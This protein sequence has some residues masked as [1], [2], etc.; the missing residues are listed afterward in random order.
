MPHAW[1]SVP[2]STDCPVHALATSI[3]LYLGF[4]PSMG[5]DQSN[6]TRI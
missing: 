4:R 6:D 1:E 2:L 3:A 5:W